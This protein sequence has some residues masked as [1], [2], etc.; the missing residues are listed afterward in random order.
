MQPDTTEVKQRL[1]I[2]ISDSILLDMQIAL[3]RNNP[4][5]GCANKLLDYLNMEPLDQEKSQRRVHHN[6][7]CYNRGVLRKLA[8]IKVAQKAGFPLVEIKQTMSQ[9]STDKT[10]TSED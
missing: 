5:T 1:I 6:H 4:F 2:Q 9:L 3:I 7:K 10:V 8:L